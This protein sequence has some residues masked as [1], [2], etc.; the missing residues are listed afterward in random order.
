MPRE[1]LREA[2]GGALRAGREPGRRTLAVARRRLPFARTLAVLGSAALGI[3]ALGSAVLGSAAVAW[4]EGE[5]EAHGDPWMAI[6]W[7]AVNFAVLAG[8]LWYFLR[9]PAGK[10]LR[11]AAQRAKQTLEDARAG[12]V[13]MEQKYNDQRRNIENLRT[14]LERLRDEARAETAVEAERLKHDAQAAADRM[15]AQVQTQVEQA[16]KQALQS[17]RAE[18][19]EEAVR[20]AERLIRQKLD[21]PAQRRLLDAQIREQERTS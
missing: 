14:E 16:R 11:E 6:V 17:I 10:A 1:T 9:K 20:T 7:K 3:T 18:L 4:A 2:P 5:G 21:E 19:A 8:L 15:T 12:A 13:A